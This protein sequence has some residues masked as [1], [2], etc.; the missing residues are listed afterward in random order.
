M[1]Q[2]SLMVSADEFLDAL[3]VLANTQY[4]AARD[5]YFSKAENFVKVTGSGDD[6]LA[7]KVESKIVL[8]E[9]EAFLAGLLKKIT[10]TTGA[11]DE[12]ARNVETDIYQKV[13]HDY[14]GENGVVTQLFGM[15]LKQRADKQAQQWDLKARE[16]YDLKQDWIQNVSYLKEV[17]TKRWEN[18]AQEF[19]AKWKDWRADFK[20][21]H[22]ANQALFLNKIEQAVQNKETWTQNFLQA[23]QNKAD[24]MTLKEMYDSIAGMVQSMQ[25]NLPQ[26]VSL[27]VNVNDILSSVLAKKPGSLSASLMD[28]ASSIDTNFF[29]NEVKK[30]NFND[31]GVK[32]QFKSLMEKTNVLSQ[33]MVILQALESLRNMPET[34]VQLIEKENTSAMKSL[35]L[36]MG[37]GGFARMGDM[38]VR[39]IKNAAGGTEIQT[40]PTYQF[41]AYTPPTSFPLVK[42]SN[43]N[44]WD[45]SKTESLLDGKAG[46]PS[47]SDVT[48]MVRLARNKMLND[49]KKTLNTEKTRNYEAELGLAV[50]FTD[51]TDLMDAFDEFVEGTMSGQNT[52]CVGKTPEQCAK[53]AVGS[54]FLVGDVPDGDFGF[55]QFGQFYTIL[56]GKREMDKRKAQMDQA[57]NRRKTGIARMYSP[58]TAMATGTENIL[59]GAKNL[60]LKDLS[61][62]GSM[63]GK[64]LLKASTGDF[65]GAKKDL[66]DAKEYAEE[67]KNIKQIVEGFTLSM[68]GQLDQTLFQFEFANDLIHMGGRGNTI[69]QKISEANFEMERLKD[70]QGK[71]NRLYDKNQE[72]VVKQD[73]LIDNVVTTSLGVLS[74]IPP[75]APFA[76]LALVGWKATRAA[77]E[78]GPGAVALMAGSAALNAIGSG[79]GVSV[80][81]GY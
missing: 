27:S 19:G 29:L 32:E 36:T 22:E 23:S 49:F 71:T 16:F 31:K 28:R 66:Y 75:A 2:T 30:Y 40:L 76:T 64:G 51:G 15:E 61:Q 24:E 11:P 55:V 46:A 38:Y 50:G 54:G 17:G 52:A 74:M 57:R 13:I 18:M 21:E 10:N 42:D 80:N 3:G 68:T 72:N 56:K 41:F 9:R 81:V 69:D 1:R 78:G 73:R 39:T 53:A 25:E 37:Y 59:K 5:A 45:L 58:Y 33:N 65:S 70:Q 62:M 26:G 4:E 20:A 14:M 12:V 67:N 43:G 6:Q 79:V 44:E 34:F 48:V 63:I 8:Q 7:V 77:Y 35:D 47:S 60:S